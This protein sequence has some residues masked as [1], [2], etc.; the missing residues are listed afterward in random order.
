M[1]PARELVPAKHVDAQEDRLG[2]ESEP[3]ERK[4]EYLLWTIR[5]VA[6]CRG[7]NLLLDRVF[8]ETIMAAARHLGVD[9]EQP[10]VS[11]PENGQQ[12]KR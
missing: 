5:V 3:L 11:P 10:Q 12:G 1:S 7:I 2:K 6:G 9:L 8:D 4:R